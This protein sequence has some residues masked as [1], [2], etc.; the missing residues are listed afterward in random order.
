MSKITLPDPLLPHK[1]FLQTLLLL[2]KTRNEIEQIFLDYGLEA[3][4]DYIFN[5]VQK[6]LKQLLP[7]FNKLDPDFDK[8]SELGLAHLFTHYRKKEDELVYSPIG[9]LG[10]EGAFRIL[11]DPHMRRLITAL[12]LCDIQD[13]DIDLIVNAR[14]NYNYAPEDAQMFV[15]NFADFSG[16]K[17]ID[18]EAFVNSVQDKDSKRIFKVALEGDKN[19]LLWKLGL[20]PDKTF[21]S[22]LRDMGTDAY[23]FFQ[24]RV[25]NHQDDEAQK[26]FALFLKA[27]ERIV[28]LNADEDEK[29]TLFDDVLFQIQASKSATAVVNPEDVQIEFPIEMRQANADILSAV[30]LELLTESTTD[31]I[32]DEKQSENNSTDKE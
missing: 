29:K 24:E 8:L 26:W 7:N 9:S 31:A 15:K 28:K 2:K 25:K 3:P 21:D 30:D 12:S 1:R 11:D 16:Y 10:I 14:Y 13:T 4:D 19:M 23:Y 32:D 17:Y 6:E 22:M 5:F 27:Q 18:R 20:A